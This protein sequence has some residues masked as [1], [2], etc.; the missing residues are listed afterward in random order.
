MTYTYE[1]YKK[2]MKTFKFE[3]IKE[4]DWIFAVDDENNFEWRQ[5]ITND[6]DNRRVKILK[7]LYYEYNDIKKVTNQFGNLL[8]DDNIDWTPIDEQ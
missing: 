2:N 3:N 7:H 8:Y 4:G 5:V 1:E 6:I